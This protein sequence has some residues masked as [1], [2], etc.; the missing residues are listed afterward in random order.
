MKI[1]RAFV[2]TRKGKSNDV[3][4]V[5]AIVH[6]RLYLENIRFILFIT[7]FYLHRPTDREALGQ[8]LVNNVSI[9]MGFFFVFTV[10]IIQLV[11]YSKKCEIVCE[12]KTDI[13]FWYAG[14]E[15]SRLSTEN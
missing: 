14:F 8:K 7:F 9:F 11:N 5:G 13:V 2:V 3:Q 6:H 4:N 12:C 15:L 10:Q 1:V